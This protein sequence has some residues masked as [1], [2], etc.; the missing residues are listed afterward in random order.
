MA[1]TCTRAASFR[2]IVHQLI[3]CSRDG[4]GGEAREGVVVGEEGRALEASSLIP[5]V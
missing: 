4:V 2:V 5:Q 3:S 1:Q